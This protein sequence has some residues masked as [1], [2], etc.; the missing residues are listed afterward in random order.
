MAAAPAAFGAPAGAR[1]REGAARRNWH[2]WRAL[3]RGFIPCFIHT[4][5]FLIIAAPHVTNF[6]PFSGSLLYGNAK[7][8]QADD[9]SGRWP[10][11]E[12]LRWAKVSVGSGDRR[13]RASSARGPSPASFGVWGLTRARQSFSARQQGRLA[14]RRQEWSMSFLRCAP[15]T[16]PSISHARA[17]LSGV[18]SIAAQRRQ[19]GGG[20]SRR[21]VSRVRQAGRQR[22]GRRQQKG[23]TNDRGRRRRRHG[24][25]DRRRTTRA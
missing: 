3:S 18:A 6:V 8:I 5:F 21:G 7:L 11:R 16:P 13:H 17:T 19:T 20:S 24:L 23:S 1:D 22:R 12:L 15:H 9:G 4:L 25:D 2:G 14:R 10:A